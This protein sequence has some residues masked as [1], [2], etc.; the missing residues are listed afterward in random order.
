MMMGF[1]GDRDQLMHLE[2]ACAQVGDL[3]VQARRLETDGYPE[4]AEL[5]R[6]QAVDL[7]AHLER[8]GPMR[9]LPRP[10]PPKE[11]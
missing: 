2:I 7:L 6:K 10:A 8:P 5:V 3:L 9:P 4:R 1:L 11:A